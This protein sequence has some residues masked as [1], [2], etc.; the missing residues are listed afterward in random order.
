LGACTRS[1]MVLP[2]HGRQ[3][4]RYPER[5]AGGFSGLR[6]AGAGKSRASLPVQQLDVS[7]Y[8]TASEVGS[9]G[10]RS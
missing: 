9:E 10:G 5:G 2:R 6:R 8:L 7:E 4:M 1:G 3:E